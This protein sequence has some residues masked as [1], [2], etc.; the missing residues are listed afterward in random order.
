MNKIVLRI[1]I[2]VIL[3][4]SSVV[5]FAQNDYAD[6]VM[7]T[8]SKSRLKQLKSVLKLDNNT[9]KNFR[10][11][12]LAYEREIAAVNREFRLGLMQADINK[13]SSQ[14]VELM[15]DNHFLKSRKILNIRQKYYKR[16]LTVLNPH[17]VVR[18]YRSESDVRRK[19]LNESQRRA[20]QN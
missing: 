13:L 9:F 17:Q 6:E 12:Y 10:P 4:F 5:V 3:G 14:E 19:V 11:I 8:M 7:Q 20:L 1:F 16:F 2:V 15:I 18:L